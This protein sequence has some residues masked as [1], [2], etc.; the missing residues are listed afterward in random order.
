MLE[1][2]HIKKTFSF[3]SKEKRKVKSSAIRLFRKKTNSIKW[4]TLT[5]SRPVPEPDANNC[6]SKFFE[7]LKQNYELKDYVIVREN[8]NK[9]GE[10]FL[11]YHVLADIPF[12]NFKILNNSWCRACR[13]FMPYSVNALTSGK[14]KIID[15]IQ[16]LVGYITK[17]ISKADMISDT[18]VYFISR[19]CESAPAQISYNEY[20]YFTT[21]FESFTIVKDHFTIVFLKNFAYVP[22]MFLAKIQKKAKIPKKIP[23]I[24]D[25]FTPNLLF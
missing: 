24:R 10:Y 13:G 17:Y 21:S 23:V 14:R 22:E 15:N 6:L 7:N 4:F 5:F 2:S 19:G 18:R 11:H 20:I 9:A 3:S 1:I 8:Q 16:G 25:E 12:T